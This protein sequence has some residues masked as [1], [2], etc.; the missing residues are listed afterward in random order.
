MIFGIYGHVKRLLYLAGTKSVEICKDKCFP[1][2]PEYKGPTWL[3]CRFYM[4]DNIIQVR[5][6]YSGGIGPYMV[7]HYD[8]CKINIHRPIA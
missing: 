5:P 7:H 4:H 3:K 8:L 2:P 1:P 6:W